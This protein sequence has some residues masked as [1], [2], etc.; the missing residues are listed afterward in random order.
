MLKK[1]LTYCGDGKKKSVSWEQRYA[2]GWVKEKYSRPVGEKERKKKR[3]I[4][5]EH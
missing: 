4:F 3:K 2:K 1:T 5:S